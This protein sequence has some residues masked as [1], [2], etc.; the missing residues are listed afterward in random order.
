MSLNSENHGFLIFFISTL[1]VTQL[2]WADSYNYNDIAQ[3]LATAI[4]VGI[5][6]NWCLKKLL[7]SYLEQIEKGNWQRK[8]ND[9]SFTLSFSFLW[10]AFYEDEQILA[11][12]VLLFVIYLFKSNDKA[13]NWITSFIYSKNFELTLDDSKA[14]PILTI[15]GKYTSDNLLAFQYLCVDLSEIF[16]KMKEKNFKIVR[17]DLKITETSN[18]KILP[19]IHA[20]ADSCD[21]K[22]TKI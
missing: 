10:V 8:I 6:L 17:I 5:V 9:I 7:D 16:F 13:R 3:R 20:I 2:R 1:I 14:P 19:L 21:I 4:L 22:Y 12:M 11:V 18:E 15:K